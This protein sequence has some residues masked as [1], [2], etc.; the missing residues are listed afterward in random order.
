MGIYIWWMGEKTQTLVLNGNT[1]SLSLEQVSH[2]LAIA[3]HCS[4]VEST[5]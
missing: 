1:N 3:F 4:Q 2:M 5:L